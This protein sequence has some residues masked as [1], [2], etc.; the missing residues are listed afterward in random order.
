MLSDERMH[1]LLKEFKSHCPNGL[2]GG[3]KGIHLAMTALNIAEQRTPD[4][5]PDLN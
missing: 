1:W 3:R 5:E 2:F 4:Q